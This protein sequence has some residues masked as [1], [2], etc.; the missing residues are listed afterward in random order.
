[1]TGNT[2]VVRNGWL[3]K[4]IMPNNV[5]RSPE[6]SF[7]IAKEKWDKVGGRVRGVHITFQGRIYELTRDEF[8][9]KKKFC[10]YGNG[11]NYR[12]AIS[13]WRVL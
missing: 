9:L 6:P 5:L 8:N 11:A 2:G 7:T 10:D 1:M 13:D 3:A 4:N 12:I